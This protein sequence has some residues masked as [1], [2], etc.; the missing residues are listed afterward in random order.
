MFES[1]D[2]KTP[3][4]DPSAFVL[5]GVMFGWAEF[6]TLSTAPDAAKYNP[7]FGTYTDFFLDAMKQLAGR[8]E[9]RY[10]PAKQKNAPIAMSVKAPWLG[11]STGIAS[12]RSPEPSRPITRSEPRLR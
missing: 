12:A 6:L 5:G 2:G 11:L 3:R 7:D 9:G 4:V 1:F 10:H 8:L